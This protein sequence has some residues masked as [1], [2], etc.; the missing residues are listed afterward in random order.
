MMSAGAWALLLA[1]PLRF[2]IGLDVLPCLGFSF[3]AWAIGFT[4]LFFLRNR[5]QPTELAE[6]LNRTVPG[7]E[8][9]SALFLAAE[10]SL[11]VMN[12]MQ[13]RRLAVI[14][15]RLP[16][17]GLL[18][19]RSVRQAL[20]YFA[21]S[22]T[23]TSA[24]VA[25]IPKD[26]FQRD[27]LGDAGS[28][29]APGLPADRQLPTILSTRV[30][31]KPP[32]YTGMKPRSVEN[33]N[34]EVEEGAT[35]VWE[36]ETNHE[37]QQLTLV[38]SSGDSIPMDRTDEQRYVGRSQVRQSSI[39][40]L[41]IQTASGFRSSEYFELRVI[42]DAAPTVVLVEPKQ[43]TTIKP[44]QLR[45]TDLT[46]TVDDDYRVTDARIIVT[47]SK[48]SGEGI[49]FREQV[50]KFD[51]RT[52]KSIG[53]YEYRKSLDFDGL[54]MAPGDELYF[55]V[56]AWDNREPAP[57]RGRSE[58]Y[59]IVIEDTAAAVLLSDF[60]LGINPLPEY[61]RSQRQIIIDTEK[62]LQEK[63]QINETEFKRRSNNLGIDQKALRLRYGQFLGEESA[64]LAV[65]ATENATEPQPTLLDGG[66]G[67]DTE[68]GNEM[69]NPDEQE[70][71]IPGDLMHEHDYEEN[72]TLFG[73]SIKT[74]LKAALAEMWDAELNLRT[75]ETKD[76][77]P[78]EYRA[79]V[80]LKRVQQHAR[81][82]VKRIGFEP[83]PLEPDEKRLSGD[84]SKIESKTATKVLGKKRDPA[85]DIRAG[86]QVI[87]AWKRNQPEKSLAQT[88][89]L[90][91]AGQVMAHQ[92]L[93]QSGSY[94]QAL[95]DLRVL[96]SSDASNDAPHWQQCL[97][98]VER[99]FWRLLPNRHPL[100]DRRHS[101]DSE[102]SRRY[103]EKLS[104][105]F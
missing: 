63:E 93:V 91:R 56:E 77:L 57:N 71:V 47:V 89:A 43:R 13:R 22:L 101:G 92:V 3:L 87:R 17:T 34:L 6:H 50:L 99:A 105:S 44:T 21:I 37:I 24:S 9:S 29:T 80:L 46:V 27:R 36:V 76:A 52:Q 96:I 83:P 98:S 64:E 58:T 40:N 20:V 48:G 16:C 53:T 88:E 39:Y 10:S 103:S 41:L 59:F 66:A 70:E 5:S 49:K 38:M 11:S 2:W 100:P 73:E 74:Q 42:D 14:L 79:L 85:E 26:A 8:E 67:F 51:K 12:Q 33:L 7:L 1:V 81:I 55:F 23:L 31:I 54:E 65:Q 102:L 60:G 82:Y 95:N 69:R 61:F 84:L 78:F 28:E 68:H 72:A 18:P 4:L 62:L 86:L 90:E 32:A 30:Q 45:R 35:V 94:L 15:D 75:F 97:L 25:F 19:T 104:R